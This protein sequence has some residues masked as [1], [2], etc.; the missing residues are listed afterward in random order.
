LVAIWSTLLE[1]APW[2]L[3]GALVSGLLHVAL[4]K[5]FV[6]RHLRGNAGVGKAVLLGVPMPLCSCGVIPNGIGLKKEGASDG[7]SV[8]FLVS[9]PQTGVDSIFVSAGMLGWPFALLKVVAAVVTG[10]IAGWTVDL[11]G[12]GAIEEPAPLGDDGAVEGSAVSRVL[13]YGEEILESIW[14][15]LVFGVLVSAALQVWLPADVLA[16]TVIGTGIAAGLAVLVFSLPL[17]VCATA[18]VPIAAGL[19]HAGLPPSAALVF[20]LAGPASNVAT[21][22]AIRGAFG[23]RVLG[24]YLAVVALGSLGFGLLFDAVL[25][26]SGALVHA[27]EHHGPVS[28]MS[29]VLLLGI[30]ARFAWRELAERLRPAPAASAGFVELDVEGV[31][32]QGC[33]RKLDRFVGEVDGVQGVEVYVEAG[34]VVVHGQPTLDAVRDAIRAAGFRPV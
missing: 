18:S 24:I 4:P 29:A 16:D 30:L 32:C 7:A 1:L 13:S 23:G 2:L 33:A 12:E 34:H 15:W 27:H 19:M 5:G 11:T 21:M 8:A 20:L 14:V 3:F 22:G 6:R 28:V 10:L 25:P 26:A 9:T 31:S 17:Y